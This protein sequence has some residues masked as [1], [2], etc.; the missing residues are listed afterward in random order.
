M[1]RRHLLSI[2]VKFSLLSAL[3][4]AL[5]CLTWGGQVILEEKR[6]LSDKLE[7]NGR[8][9]LTSLKGPII[10]TMIMGEMGLVPGLLD[11]YVEEIVRNPDFPTL[12]AFIVD[13]EGKVVAHS[14]VSN[15]GKYFKDPLTASALAGDGY[16]SATVADQ[17][18]RIL[19]TA[20]PLNIAGKS[21]G[22]LRV[23]FSM[24][25]SEQEY[26]A[27]MMRIV[28]FSV[29]VFLGC[30]V[31]FFFIGRAMSHPL[32]QLAQAMAHIELGAFN[33]NPLP[34]RND[35]IGLLQESFQRML[36][37]L[38]RSEQERENALNYVIQN[39]KMATIGKIVAGVAHEVNN[40]L[41]AISACI[42]KVE[43]K[44]APEARTSWEVLKAGMVRI[45]KIVK[46]LSD[47]SRVGALELQYVPS[48]Q[49]F[50]ETKAFALMALEKHH[51]CLVSVDKCLP[52]VLLHIDKGKLHQVVLN[53][54]INATAAS[55]G[56]GMIELRACVS[57]GAYRLSV[58]DNGSGIAEQDLEKIF[59]IF[60]TTKPAGSGSG[61]G[62]AV[63]KSIIDLH[64]GTIEVASKEGET[65]F[66]V[67]IPLENGA[68][69]D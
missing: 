47:F 65:V 3:I 33:A 30:T 66:S 35:E 68:C 54:V 2:K 31:V 38:R 56:S 23:G 50:S 41:A 7:V 11:N 63:C 1:N 67:V 57:G 39:E 49:F 58:R 25:P 61:I 18:G 22:A 46:Q 19:D 16:Q 55:T 24:T 44:V 64:R 28:L 52:P 60:F 29:L 37:R 4:I 69:N 15:Y 59:D 51:S 17:R 10:N 32:Q 26:Q 9:L 43:T 20:L 6:H 13:E 48:D 62:L 42:Y 27:F 40:P 45:E 5:F 53:L 34:P 14:D 36:E 8:L 12:Y 21:W